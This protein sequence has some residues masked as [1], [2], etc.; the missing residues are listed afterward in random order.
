MSFKYINPGYGALTV[1]S[2]TTTIESS[3]YNPTNSV[4]FNKFQ[5]G[6]DTHLKINLPEGLTSDL[7]CKFDFYLDDST[8]TGLYFGDYKSNSVGNKAWMNGIEVYYRKVFIDTSAYKLGNGQSLNVYSL[9]QIWFHIHF[10]SSTSDS[11]GELKVNDNTIEKIMFSSNQY[12]DFYPFDSSHKEFIIV[13]PSYSSNPVWL[14]NLIISNE[15]IDPKEKVLVLP[16]SST[17]S[18]MTFDSSTGIYSASTAGEMVLQTPD[19][20]NLIQN[21]GATSQVKGICLVGKPA[22]GTGAELKSLK[23]I[24]KVGSTV[25]EYGSC[26]LSEDSGGAIYDSRSLT[27]LTIADL[28]NMQFGWKAGA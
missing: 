25:T 16:V 1:D 4:A 6:R 28:Q 11:Y 8:I 20:A 14:S 18:T 19:V 15:E 13:F 26:S 7:Y 27:N 2:D 24:Q 3:V 22:Y 23:A 10:G 5:S 9:N 12:V 21:Y 17:S